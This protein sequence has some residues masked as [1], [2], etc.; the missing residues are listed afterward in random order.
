MYSP[1]FYVIAALSGWVAT[2]IVLSLFG[3]TWW[4]VPA[5]TALSALFVIALRLCGVVQ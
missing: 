2:D 5:G 4:T 3:R 1:S